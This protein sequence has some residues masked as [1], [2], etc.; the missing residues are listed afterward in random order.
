MLFFAELGDVRYNPE[1]ANNRPL[2]TQGTAISRNGL[3][4]LWNI[5][6]RCLGWLTADTSANDFS[7]LCARLR[8][9]GCTRQIAVQHYL[10]CRSSDNHQAMYIQIALMSMSDRN[11][12]ITS[13]TLR[14]E[15]VCRVERA[16]WGGAESHDSL[17]IW[18]RYSDIRFITVKYTLNTLS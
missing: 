17:R 1:R 18:Y 11:R 6:F 15:D 4:M 2:S 5:L 16:N 10:F 7:S 13:P 8:A 9:S 14:W 3:A 12:A